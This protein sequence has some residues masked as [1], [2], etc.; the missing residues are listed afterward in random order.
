M[1]ATP[2]FWAVLEF[3]QRKPPVEKYETWL[4]RSKDLPL[5]I[6]IGPQPFNASSIKHAKAILRLTKPHFER[7]RSISTFALPDKVFRVIFDRIS[8]DGMGRLDRLETVKVDQGFGVARYSTRPS[9]RR[10]RRFKPFSNTGE[11]PPALRNL[12]LDGYSARY[13]TGRCKLFQVWGIIKRFVLDPTRSLHNFHDFLS[14]LQNLRILEVN[15]MQFGRYPVETDIPQLIPVSSIPLSTHHSLTQL[16]LH[17]KQ[18]TRNTIMS[19]LILPNLRY[20]LNPRRAEPAISVSCLSHLSRNHPFPQLVS[21]RLSISHLPDDN[22]IIMGHLEGALAGLPELKILTFDHVDF[23]QPG[24]RGSYLSCLGRA[25]LRLRCLILFECDGYTLENLVSIGEERQ[26]AEG[27]GSPLRIVVRAWE[28]P[29]GTAN[30]LERLKQLVQFERMK[31][32]GG[33]HTFPNYFVLG[34]WKKS[35]EM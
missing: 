2:A 7:W 30:E 6:F 23:V 27:L 20:P 5:D 15:D 25:C 28:L 3:R 8:L 34:E 16:S 24:G 21:L 4:E 10:R 11:A 32:Q 18:T 12:I 33:T 9:D 14:A 1:L 22:V 31:L 29:P 13:F 26:G 17:A 19:S 35:M